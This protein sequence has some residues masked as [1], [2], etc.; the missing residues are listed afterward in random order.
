MSERKTIHIYPGLIL[1]Y[2]TDK[3]SNSHKALLK[4]QRYKPLTTHWI[5]YGDAFRL[6]LAIEATLITQAKIFNVERI[7]K[8]VGFVRFLLTVG[9][10]N[11]EG[12][13]S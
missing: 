6:R 11:S 7:S 2:T 12:K 1:A 8:V 4:A 10:S 9:V 3:N 5:I 13:F